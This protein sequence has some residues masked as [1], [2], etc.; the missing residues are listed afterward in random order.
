MFESKYAAALYAY[1]YQT[2]GPPVG[3]KGSESANK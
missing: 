2:T 1:E 3:P